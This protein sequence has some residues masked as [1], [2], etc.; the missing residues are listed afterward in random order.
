MHVNVTRCLWRQMD[1]AGCKQQ[2]AL[3]SLSHPQSSFWPLDKQD[4]ELS[5]QLQSNT[6]G[7]VRDYSKRSREHDK[8]S[9]AVLIPGSPGYRRVDGF[10]CLNLKIHECH[11]RMT[12][13][14]AKAKTFQPW[15]QRTQGWTRQHRTT[16]SLSRADRDQLFSLFSDTEEQ[17]EHKAGQ[18]QTP[19]KMRRASVQQSSRTTEIAINNAGNRS[20]RRMLR[21]NLREHLEGLI[22]AH[23]ACSPS[24]VRGLSWKEPDTARAL[25]GGGT[26]LSYLPPCWSSLCIHL[27]KLEG[28]KTELTVPSVPHSL[29][30][31]WSTS[32]FSAVSSELQVTLSRACIKTLPLSWKSQILTA[33]VKAKITNCMKTWVY[34]LQKN[35][36]WSTCNS[37]WQLSDTW[38]KKFEAPP[39]SGLSRFPAEILLN[40]HGT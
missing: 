37:N 7:I 26:Y 14:L 16:C 36:M 21:S 39:S 12:S 8:P 17:S 31:V 32:L 18:N 11:R 10:G 34:S 19:N 22:A 28:N 30:H 38:L 15:K 4:V 40:Q 35:I 29:T 6:Q 5:A 27:W 2:W 20:S 25:Q 23:P 9:F 1:R 13:H 33:E 3:N 24:R